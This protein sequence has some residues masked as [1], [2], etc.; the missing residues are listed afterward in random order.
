MLEEGEGL[1]RYIGRVS[2]S[3][4]SLRVPEADAPLVHEILLSRDQF[5]GRRAGQLPDAVVTWNGLPPL[6]RIYSDTIGELTSEPGTG[7]AGNHRP[8]GFCVIL[9]RGARHE[10]RVP[11]P[12][13]ISELGTFVSALLLS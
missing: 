12:Q 11:P 6:S 9:N 10:K 5:P 3:L 1:E 7:R 4:M 2:H 13:H 8:D